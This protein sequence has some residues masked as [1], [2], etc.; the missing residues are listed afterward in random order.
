MPDKW[1]IRCSD[2]RT[3]AIA[4]HQAYLPWDLVGRGRT[5]RSN[6]AETGGLCLKA[7]IDGRASSPS[8]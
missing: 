4:S 7:V 6:L 8:C 2:H 5:A 1:R 3:P